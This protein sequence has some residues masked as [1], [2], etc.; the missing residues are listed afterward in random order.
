MVVFA[1]FFY[2]ALTTAGVF[3]LRK[4]MPD[5]H[6]P[7]KVWGYP[8]IP[9]IFILFCMGLIVNTMITQPREA[10]FGLV[11]MLTGVP[12]YYYFSRKAA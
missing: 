5:A 2:Y 10:I 9:A 7:Y 8:V 6:R 12:M 11:L 3:I 1:I 4:T